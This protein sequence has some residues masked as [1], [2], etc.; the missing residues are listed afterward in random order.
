M[1]SFFRIIKF[2]FQDIFRNFSLS[3]MTVLILVLMLLSVNALIGI[4]A[5][6]GQATQMIKD[7]IDVSVYFNYTATDESINEIRSFIESFP[8]VKS[9]TFKT[10]DIVLSEF[11]EDHALNPDILASLDELGENPFGA[12]LIVRTDNPENYANIITAI[13]IPEYED[14]IDAKTFDETQVTIDNVQNITDRVE[15]ISWGLT[16]M[17]AVIAFVIVFNTV[18]VAIYTQRAE[19]SIKKLVGA[20]DS[21]VKGPYHIQS[22]LFT[23]LS[24]GI[25]AGII[26]YLLQH[27][28]PYLALVLRQ[29]QFLTNYYNSNIIFLLCSQVAAVLLL[30]TFSATL[31]MRKYLKT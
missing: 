31:A 7:Q 11:R 24:V 13:N 9:T 14:L 30:T 20:T 18:R 26:Y 12:T 15:T 23:A 10:P 4:R 17:F 25:T 3:F 28:D 21:F 6:T 19:I 1:L 22:L 16:L 8:E 27:L 5:V 2:A 29:D